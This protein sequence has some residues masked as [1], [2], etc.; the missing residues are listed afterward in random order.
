[1]PVKTIK[2]ESFPARAMLLAA[3]ALLL[4]GAFFSVKWGLANSASSKAEVKEVADLTVRWA[5]DDP[6]THYVSA[7]LYE[8]TFLPEDVPVSLAEYE[9]AAALAPYNFLLWLELGKARERSGDAAAAERTLRRALELAPNYAQVRWALGN[10]LLRQGRSDEA[11]A[12]IRQAVASDEK[13]THPAAAMAWQVFDGDIAV[14]RHTIGDSPRINAALAS[15]LVSQK[16]LDEALAIWSSLAPEEK[17]VTYKTTSESLYAHLVEAKKYNAAL[18]VFSA[19]YAGEGEEEAGIGKIFNGGFE[20]AIK[21]Q[22]PAIFEWQIAE[23]IKP[24]AGPDTG[25]KHSGDRS[26]VLIFN[27]VDGKDFRAISQTVAVEPGRT[28]QFDLFY[29]SDLRSAATLKWE[30]AGLPDGKVIGATE[31]VAEI[32]DWTEQRIK[33]AVPA[34]TEAVVIRLAR[35][36]CGRGLCPISG[37]IWFDDFTLS[38]GQ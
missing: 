30:V 1:M 35:V 20:S 37:R 18:N 27:S 32:A 31:P 6:Q 23:A 16:R 8:R 38:A 2:I 13:Y 9:K 11:F 19:V 7:V 25:Q 3:A 14:V 10:N 5:P 34:N 28:Y 29:K 33:F 4:T 24:Q 36:L 17:R 26:L 12:E 21:P 15:L 22:N